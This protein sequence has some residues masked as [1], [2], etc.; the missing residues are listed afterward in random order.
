MSLAIEDA[1]SKPKTRKPRRSAWQKVHDAWDDTPTDDLGKLIIKHH[2]G[3]TT[4]DFF[5]LLFE[6]SAQKVRE[7]EDE[8]DQLWDTIGRLEDAF[9]ADTPAK[10]KRPASRDLILPLLSR[11]LGKSVN[12]IY[13][14]LGGTWKHSQGA[15]IPLKGK[16]S[17]GT[18]KNVF[19]ALLA[20][21][22][23]EIASGTGVNK[24]PY[25]YCLTT[26]HGA[27]Q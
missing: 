11:D 14:A 4:S 16:L 18:V 13:A 20:E 1:A 23:I 15:S 21:G 8:N 9:C 17:I 6:A 22:L 2:K 24:D 19:D 12:D 10:P 27:Q 7:L 25:L 5:Y 26:N 3:L